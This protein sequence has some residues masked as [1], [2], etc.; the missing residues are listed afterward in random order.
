MRREW[1]V[2]CNSGRRRESMNAASAVETAQL[3]KPPGIN[4]LQTGRRPR[5]HFPVYLV[6][7]QIP[8]CTKLLLITLS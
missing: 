3:A 8:S 6:S 2:T 1:A 5:A 4:G 7:Y